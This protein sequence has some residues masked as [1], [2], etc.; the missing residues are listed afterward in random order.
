MS[1]ACLKICACRS[2]GGPVEAL[3]R[4]TVERIQRFLVPVPATKL[5]AVSADY[6]RGH[7]GLLALVC[8]G[9]C[10]IT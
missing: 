5:R 3:K 2:A 10:V 9:E 1:H 8:L 4:L 7:G 6:P